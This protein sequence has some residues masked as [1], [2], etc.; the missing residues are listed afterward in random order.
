VPDQGCYKDE[1]W[2][3]RQKNYAAMIT[4]MDADLGRLFALLEELGIDEKTIVFFTSDNGPNPPFIETFDSNGPFRGVKRQLYEGGIRMP[5]IVR[6]PGQVPA[7]ETSDFVWTFTDFFPTAA[8]LGGIEPPGDLD[9]MNVLPALRGEKQNAHD[10][11]YWEFHDPFHQAVR[12]GEWKGIRFGTEEPIELY[13]LAV[14]RGETTDVAKDHPEIVA[15]MKSIMNEEHVD[16]VYW[17]LVEHPKRKAKK[18]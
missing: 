2:G 6:W 3:G 12:K 1:P 8:A 5:M 15:A 16:S 10:H 4:R 13:N 11:L 9:G 18:K 7:G 17:P 14:D